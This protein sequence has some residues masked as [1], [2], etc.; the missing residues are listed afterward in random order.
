M[1]VEQAIKTL[2]NSLRPSQQK[3]FINLYESSAMKNVLHISR[4]FGKT[5][6]LIVIAI[7]TAISAPDQQIR[8]ATVTQKAAKKMVHPQIKSLFKLLPAK[9]RGRWN[10]Q[11]G[12]YKFPNG[13]EIHLAGVNNGNAEDLRGTES[14]L[15]IVDEASF[16]DELGYLIDS[17]LLPQHITTKGKLLISSS[18]PLSPAHEFVS[19]IQEAKQND[20]YLAYN[21]YQSDY[22]QDTIEFFA[23]ETGG[24]DSIAWRREYENELIVDDETSIIPEWHDSLVQDFT[25]DEY[26]KFYHNYE[27]LDI[28]VR[29]KTAILFGFY[30]FKKATLFIEDEFTISGPE[31]TT[32][33]IATA[34]K[35]KEKILNY[36]KVYKRVADNNNLLLL[37]DLN[38]AHDLVFFPTSK[39]SLAA[40]VNTVRLLVKDKRI[41][42]HPRCKE[43]IGCLQYGV[44]KDNSRS[45]FGRS[46]TYGHYDTLSSLIYLA[47]S[48][49]LTTNPIPQ[50]YNY[51]PNIFDPNSYDNNEGS[52]LI[53]KVFNI[54]RK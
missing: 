35:E 23:K 29:D 52:D 33:N 4:R 12:S 7:I 53:R 14:H 1:T 41:I 5:R 27:S 44:Y 47:R 11:D 17:V 13:S 16:I 24:K 49:D 46:K 48:L 43:L 34:V 9:F 6:I 36:E 51:N 2:F 38:T 30:D 25:T 32:R 45:E 10:T 31:T 20:A 15:S 8:F 28:G 39:E 26:R 19:Y 22:D 40:M 42:V 18:S 37:N 3:V 54:K 21:I 50:S